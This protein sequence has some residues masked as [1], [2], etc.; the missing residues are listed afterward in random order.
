MPKIP[1]IIL[2]GFLGSGKT[3]LL[4]RTLKQKELQN[5]AIIVN[6]FGKIGLDH[7][8]LSNV[9]ERTLLIGG[10]CVCC[11]TREDLVTA[12]MALLNDMQKGVQPKVDRVIVETTGLADPSPIWFTLLRHPVLQHHFDVDR[13]LVAIDAVNGMFHLDHHQES[14]KQAA[15]AD[16]IIITKTDIASSGQI[17]QL[18]ERIPSINPAASIVTTHAEDTDG[19]RFFLGDLPPAV[20]TVRTEGSADVKSVHA[21]DTRSISIQFDTPLDWHAFGLW[22]S[23]LL[24]ARGTHILRVKGLLDLGGQGPVSLNGVQ[25]II[26]PPEHLDKWP[27]GKRQSNIVFIMKKVEP[28]QILDSLLAFQHV[29]GAVP[30]ALEIQTAI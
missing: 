13:I 23:M 14:M 25:H 11:S 8:L 28:Q 7:H 18:L 15:I 16:Q 27:A 29:L 24:H 30:Y 1:V 2:S 12:F 19:S 20:K 9:E 6:E 4:T 22:L 17:E 21:G 10:G 5:S 3:S 26:H